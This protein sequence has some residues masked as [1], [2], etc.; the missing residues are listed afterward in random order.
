MPTFLDQE[1][2]VFDNA[3]L[4][5]L[6]R[7]ECGDNKQCLFDIYTTGKVNIGKASKQSVESF[8]AVINETE[9]PGKLSLLIRKATRNIYIQKYM[10]HIFM[11]KK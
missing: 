9:T 7:A 11:V 1:D 2:L 4:G 3:T 8:V 6:A 10:F 5:K